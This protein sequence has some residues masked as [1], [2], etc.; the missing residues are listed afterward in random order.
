[1]RQSA[2]A[3][4]VPKVGRKEDANDSGV[5]D[6]VLESADCD[7]NQLST[8]GISPFCKIIAKDSFLTLSLMLSMYIQPV[9]YV[10]LFE[11]HNVPGWQGRQMLLF[12]LS[13]DEREYL[14]TFILQGQ[15]G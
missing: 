7:R 4:R 3:G 2:L 6:E 12:H 1:M 15:R 10:L 13:P 11:L 5:M 9:D 14:G 8:L